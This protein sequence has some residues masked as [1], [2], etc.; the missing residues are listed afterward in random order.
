MA[1]T[2]AITTAVSGAAVQET[3]KKAAAITY[4]KAGKNTWKYASGRSKVAGK[5]GPL[6]RYRVVVEK[7]ITGIT[8]NQFAARVTK[9]L[10]DRRS[11][12]GTGT[13]RLQRVPNSA[14]YDFTIYL[15]TPQTRDTLCQDASKADPDRYTSCRN[16]DR[17]VLNVARWVHGV[18]KYGASLET[19]R[20]YMINHET[21]HRLGYH[22]QKCPAK[23]K[24]APVMQ[25]QTL[26]LHGCT[27]NPWPRVSGKLYQ[28]PAGAY[29]DP[30]P[31]A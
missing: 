9:T 14:K 28:G 12:T 23:G 1:I 20:S 30:I 22:H 25:Q 24:K 15:A 8:A 10:A 7:G 26:G 13:V 11:W 16:G 19:Y 4:P 6:L 17:V 18:P 5:K 29:S 27:A 2:T 31:K 3:A 21:G